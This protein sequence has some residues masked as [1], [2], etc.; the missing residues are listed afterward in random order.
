PLAVRGLSEQDGER[1][2]PALPPRGILSAQVQRTHEAPKQGLERRAC[3]P[4]GCRECDRD[5]HEV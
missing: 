1:L 2:Q 4:R 3:G 5:V